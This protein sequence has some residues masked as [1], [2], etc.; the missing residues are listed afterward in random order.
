MRTRTHK[1]FGDIISEERINAPRVIPIREQPDDEMINEILWDAFNGRGK[2]AS[3]KN[4]TSQIANEYYIHPEDIYCVDWN[5][6]I[7]KALEEVR[8]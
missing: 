8:C 6:E 5:E 1:Y 4:K 7:K 3:K 2:R